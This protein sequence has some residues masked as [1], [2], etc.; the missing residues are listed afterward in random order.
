MNSESRSVNIDFKLWKQAEILA[1]DKGVT[2]TEFIEEA[3][4]E[5]IDKEKAH[6]I[7]A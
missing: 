3:V 2:T 4:K 1:I 7:Q 5:K 6:Q